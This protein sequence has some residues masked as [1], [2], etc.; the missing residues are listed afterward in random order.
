[1][2]RERWLPA[3]CA[4]VSRWPADQ[5]ETTGP[6]VAV[7]LTPHRSTLR[8]DGQDVAVV[9]VEAVDAEGRQIPTASQEITFA[10]TGAGKIC[11]VGNG[12][13]SS[14]EADQYLG[15]VVNNRSQLEVQD[16]NRCRSTVG[17]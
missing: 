17:R 16:D 14:H 6:P 10:I 8:A 12:D 15:W 4:T 3:D 9:T 5:I 1:M 11:G 2:S 7:K 13:P